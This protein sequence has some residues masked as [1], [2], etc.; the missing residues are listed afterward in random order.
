MFH[1]QHHSEPSVFTAQ[2]SSVSLDTDATLAPRPLT[3]TGATRSTLVPSPTCPK[4]FQP[5]H[6]SEPSVSR[7]HAVDSPAETLATAFPRA[8]IATGPCRSTPVP[9]RPQHHRVWSVLTAQAYSPPA[10]T[11]A[12]PSPRSRTMVGGLQALAVPSP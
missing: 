1:P 10:D 5:Q 9:S 8:V 3:G 2:V 11:D 7:A 6:Q 12:T 4:A